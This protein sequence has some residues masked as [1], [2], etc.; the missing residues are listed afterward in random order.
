MLAR[1][2]FG[3][4]CTVPKV[5][6]HLSAFSS[7]E[8][9]N[10]AFRSGSVAASSSSWAMT[11]AMPSAPPLPF[12]P[13]GCAMQAFGQRVAASPMKAYLIFVP[14]SVAKVCQ[15]QYLVQNPEV[16]LTSG[17]ARTKYTPAGSVGRRPLVMAPETTPSTP[18]SVRFTPC[19][20][21]SAVDPAKRTVLLTCTLAGL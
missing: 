16:S 1:V 6:A 13:L 4:R 15:P 2:P 9:S 20:Y 14:A 3:A 21:G 8:L 19:E 5:Q 18:A 17:D 11:E 10:Q 12:G 7:P